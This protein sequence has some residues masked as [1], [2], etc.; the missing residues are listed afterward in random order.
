MA[1]GV[2]LGKARMLG[3]PRP[4]RFPGWRGEEVFPSPHV[5]RMDA[6]IL[7]QQASA[8]FGRQGVDQARQKNSRFDPACRAYDT[9]RTRAR[10]RSAGVT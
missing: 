3:H 5:V 2:R 8:E 6:L 1:G 10:W 9:H 4:P 7:G